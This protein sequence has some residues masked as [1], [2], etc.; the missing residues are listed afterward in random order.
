ML[1]VGA[2]V[3]VPVGLG[4]VLVGVTGV[5]VAGAAVSDGAVVGE[6]KTAVGEGWMGKVGNGSS[7]DAVLAPGKLHAVNESTATK[8]NIQRKGF[9][10]IS[11]SSWY[12][13]EYTTLQE[14]IQSG[15]NDTGLYNDVGPDG[16]TNMQANH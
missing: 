16:P 7:G 2:C 14:W 1:L 15:E 13:S 3:C 4:G 10:F 11:F 9:S 5:A 12:K 6:I 8:S